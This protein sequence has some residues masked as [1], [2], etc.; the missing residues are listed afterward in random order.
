MTAIIIHRQDG[1]LAGDA[2]RVSQALFNQFFAGLQAM[3]DNRSLE[4]F[5]NDSGWGRVHGKGL[6]SI[7]ILYTIF[8]KQ[9]N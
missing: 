4:G 7:E 3:V 2:K 5:D 1:E 6:R 8:A 9:C